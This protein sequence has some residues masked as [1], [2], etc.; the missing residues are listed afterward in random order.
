[1]YQEV[2]ILLST[3]W[4]VCLFVSDTSQNVKLKVVLVEE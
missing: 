2:F 1:M 3:F 4:L